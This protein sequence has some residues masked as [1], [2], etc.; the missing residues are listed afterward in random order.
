MHRA[1]METLSEF[2]VLKRSLQHYKS[3]NEYLNDFNDNLM[4]ENKRLREELEETNA[5]YQELITTAKEVMRRKK[6]TKQKNEGLTKQ[7]KEL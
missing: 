7:N 4:Q 5:N 6:L 3:H 1:P 2:E